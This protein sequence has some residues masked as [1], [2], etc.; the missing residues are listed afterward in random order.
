MGQMDGIRGDN[1]PIFLGHSGRR[2]LTAQGGGRSAIIALGLSSDGL[3]EGTDARFPWTSWAQRTRRALAHCV[4]A[5]GDTRQE[6]AFAAV[7]SSPRWGPRG[8]MRI[9][10]MR[11]GAYPDISAQPERM[12][13]TL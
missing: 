10:A 3:A 8:S 7:N 11:S 1:G 13:V 6:L 9:P 4:L 12:G 5:G 2:Q